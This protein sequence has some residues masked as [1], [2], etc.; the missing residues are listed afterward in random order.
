[1]K[2]ESCCANFALYNQAQLNIHKIITKLL[3]C[4][5]P[6]KMPWTPTKETRKMLV[7]ASRVIVGLLDT[8]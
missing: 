6:L 2:I 3:S 8:I 1:M 5:E 7:P 4:R